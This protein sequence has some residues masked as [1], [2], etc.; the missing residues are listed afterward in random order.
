MRY[1][2]S[3]IRNVAVFGG[4]WMAGIGLWMY[5]PWLSLTVIGFILFGGTVWSMNSRQYHQMRQR[6]AEQE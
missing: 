1:L 2:P 4:L 3:I 6:E 5:A